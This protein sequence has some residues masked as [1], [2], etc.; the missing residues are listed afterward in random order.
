MAGAVIHGAAVG[1]LIGAG[2]GVVAGGII[3]GA[4]TGWSAEGILIG[5]GIGFGG[6]ALIGAIIGG[7]ARAAQ[8]AHAVSQW[9]STATRTAQ[10]NMVQHFN[11]HVIGEGHKYLGKNVIQYTRNAKNFFNANH[12]IMKLTKSGNYA[13][14]ALFNGYKAGGFFSKTGLIF[15]FF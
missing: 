13:I 12:S 3:G 8:Y 9:G 5:M 7:A 2:V 14:R 15:S 11:K 1:T 4:T 10:Q 6:G